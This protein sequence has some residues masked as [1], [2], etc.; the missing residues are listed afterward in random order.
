MV[1]IF[2]SIAIAI[3]VAGILYCFFVLHRN[4]WVYKQRMKV[5]FGENGFKEFQKLPSYDA[6]MRKFWIWDVNKFKADDRTSE[7]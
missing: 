1:E 6:M 7:E 3:P 4:E 2:F 5:L